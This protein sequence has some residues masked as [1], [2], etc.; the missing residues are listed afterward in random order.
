[1]TGVINIYRCI[2]QSAQIN[3]HIP[4]KI[5]WLAPCSRVLLEKQAVS[6]SRNSSPFIKAEGSLQCSQK[7][8]LISNSLVECSQ[9][10]H[11]LFI[12]NI[13]MSSS[14]LCPHFDNAL[15]HSRAY[16]HDFSC[17]SHVPICT[18]CLVHNNL[19]H[20]VDIKI[21]DYSLHWAYAA[22]LSLLLFLNIQYFTLSSIKHNRRG[23]GCIP[24]T[25]SQDRQR[26]RKYSYV[27]LMQQ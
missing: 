23:I 27:M 21:F 7:P 24:T 25:A 20:F 8:A 26:S 13:L 3:P 1:M 17:L 10:P 14:H 18:T 19:L 16:D 22:S 6:Q 11:V 15:F 4:V 9:L 2:I 5:T 12:K